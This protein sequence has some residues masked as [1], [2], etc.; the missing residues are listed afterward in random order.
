MTHR[1]PLKTLACLALA[2]PLLGCVVSPWCRD[3][4]FDTLLSEGRVDPSALWPMPSLVLAASIVAVTCLIVAAIS[5]LATV[6]GLGAGAEAATSARATGETRPSPI[7]TGGALTPIAWVVAGTLLA[8]VALLAGGEMTLADSKTHVA[9]GWYWSEELARLRVPVWTDLWYGGY[10]IGQEYPPLAHACLG[11]W[12][13]LGLSA[14]SA[15]KVLVWTARAI[16]AAGLALLAWR[17]HRSR[18]ASIVSGL[19]FGLLPTVHA[20]AMWRGRLPESLT[21]AAMPWILVGV[22]EIVRGRRPIAGAALSA[23]AAWLAFEAHAGAALVAF[24]IGASFGAVRTVRVASALG[25]AARRRWLAERTLGI[26]VAALGAAVLVGTSA[27]RFLWSSEFAREAGRGGGVGL[28]L[29]P[30]DTLLAAVRWHPLST[31]YVGLSV[32]ILAASGVLRSRR[33]RSGGAPGSLDAAVMALVPFALTAPGRPG[34]DLAAVGLVLGVAACMASLSK[35]P[36]W[37]AAACLVLLLD[38]APFS[39]LAPYV[40]PDAGRAATLDRVETLVGDGR[41]LELPVDARGR[42]QASSWHYAPT[43]RI[44]SV[45]GPFIQGSPPAYKHQLALIDTVAASLGERALPADVAG[46]LAFHDVRCVTLTTR[47][48][49]VR[50]DV[51]ELPPG[52][53]RAPDA[54]VLVITGASPVHVLDPGDPHPPPTPEPGTVPPRGLSPEESARLTTEGLAWWRDARP[55][56]VPGATRRF[57]GPTSIF[58]LPDLGSARVRLSRNPSRH[59]VVHVD[60]EPVTWS[61]G[62][63]GGIVVDV[64]PGAHEIRIDERLPAWIA[65]SRL[66]QLLVALGLVGA[67]VRARSLQ[68]VGRAQPRGSVDRVP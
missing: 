43:R 25:G 18:V 4:L 9:R 40:H 20:C 3:R 54:P 51:P 59:A 67:G 30:A 39:L 17:L 8:T 62:P 55:R 32:V 64:A 12:I 50:P 37:V 65:L 38:V 61:A 16:G 5:V 63:L 15:A 2:W 13:D 42:A 35:R 26:L 60:G 11:V 7:T 68:H 47:T 1:A 27:G 29:P 66:A 23:V 24:G 44:P 21:I 49:H 19:V 28:S 31:T 34:A 10:P 41:W 36:R 6:R 46:L 45:G 58:A 48:G 56:P 57:E 14:S 53:T 52:V 33:A 22:E